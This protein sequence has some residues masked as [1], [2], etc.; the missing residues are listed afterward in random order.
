MIFFLYAKPEAKVLWG[1]LP[2][3]QPISY[4]YFLLVNHIPEK[5][6]RKINTMFNPTVSIVFLAEP[7]LVQMYVY[8]A[9]E[10]IEIHTQK[11]FKIKLDSSTGSFFSSREVYS[12][13]LADTA[14]SQARKGF[15]FKDLDKVSLIKVIIDYCYWQYDWIL[16]HSR[17]IDISYFGWGWPREFQRCLAQ[18]Q[19]KHLCVYFLNKTISSQIGSNNCYFWSFLKLTTEGI[20]T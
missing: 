17:N 15:I 8:Y 5:R 10:Y 12:F 14:F 6:H 11:N 16:F 20:H 1:G 4:H 9:C 2:R 18:P 3:N 13:G 7:L 19:P